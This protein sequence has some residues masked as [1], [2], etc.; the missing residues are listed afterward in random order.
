MGY[1]RSVVHTVGDNHGKIGH[2][3][4]RVALRVAVAVT[5]VGVLRAV[6]SAA[7]Q[8]IPPAGGSHI[9]ALDAPRDLDAIDQNLENAFNFSHA[10][11][12]FHSCQIPVVAGKHHV[13]RVPLRSVNQGHK[14]VIAGLIILDGRELVVLLPGPA[15][16]DGGRHEFNAAKAGCRASGCIGGKHTALFAITACV[17][18]GGE[19]GSRVQA[20]RSAALVGRVS[21]A[22]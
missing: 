1:G 12:H 19:R 18:T 2:T 9:G 17:G 14:I 7:R 22:V 5:E 13:R 6:A 8:Q 3:A 4:V 10:Q 11:Q 21:A 20:T 16:Q 15:H